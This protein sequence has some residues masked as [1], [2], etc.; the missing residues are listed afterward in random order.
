MDPELFLAPH[1]DM[2]NHFESERGHGIFSSQSET[3]KL[4]STVSFTVREKLVKL[5]ACFANSS[6]IQIL[7]AYIFAEKLE[8][9]ASKIVTFTNIVVEYVDRFFKREKLPVRKIEIKLVFPLKYFDDHYVVFLLLLFQYFP[10]CCSSTLLCRKRKIIRG[11]WII[12]SLYIFDF[13][14]LHCLK[15]WVFPMN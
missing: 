7:H 11:S 6:S 15:P 9:S 1:I 10:Q 5:N 3:A 12:F 2:C 8:W 13:Y 14:L 4:D